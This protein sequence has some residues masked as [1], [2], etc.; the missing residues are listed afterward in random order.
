MPGAAYIIEKTGVPVIPV[1]IT[2]TTD[3]FFTRA[4][5][6]KRPLLEM[7]IGKPLN[8]PPVEGIGAA[9]RE[10]LQANADQIM[11]AI[12]ALVPPESRGVYRTSSE[13]E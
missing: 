2:G 7:R 11:L 6:F 8:L 5:R 10:A 3:D 9:R 13:S 4:I 1:G 12:A